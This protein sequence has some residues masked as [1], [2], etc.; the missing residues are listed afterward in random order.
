MFK[1]TFA[2]LMAEK[3]VNALGVAAGIGV[4]KSIVYC[5]KN[6]EREPSMENLVRLARF[7]GVSIERLCD[8]PTPVETVGDR[9]LAMMLRATENV[10]KETYE[11]VLKQFKDNLRFYLTVSGAPIPTD[12][13]SQ[14]R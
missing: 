9:E 13:E 8:M 2:Q 4:P 11:R 1:D 6:G 14:S 12:D 7:F 5:W 3:H 10:S